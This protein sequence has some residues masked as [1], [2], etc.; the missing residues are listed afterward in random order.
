MESITDFIDL[1]IAV[2]TNTLGNDCLSSTVKRCPTGTELESSVSQAHGEAELKS[3]SPC[4]FPI[5]PPI[6]PST[7]N[8]LWGTTYRANDPCEDR[9]A[10][11]TN[12]LLRPN[13]KKR[14]HDSE[15]S[16]IT[17]LNE[18]S[19]MTS[20]PPRN[21]MH[22]QEHHTLYRVS[23]FCV[24]DGH[25]GPYVAD[26]ASKHLLPM[27]STNIRK[28][29]DCTY[30]AM[31][32]FRINHDF[33]SFKDD[34][35]D[36]EGLTINDPWYTSPRDEFCCPYHASVSKARAAEDTHTSDE[37]LLDCE[38]L[39][40]VSHVH[41]NEQPR[42][43]R[44]S[45]ITPT[46]VSEEDLSEGSH[47]PYSSSNPDYANIQDS[48][49]RNKSTEFP[50]L[51]DNQPI[52]VQT[53]RE[54]FLQLD[55]L[56]MNTINVQRLRPACIMTND[57]C[58]AGS[59]CLV[60]ML[61]QKSIYFI[62]SG[63]YVRFSS[64]APYLYTS[65]LGD[66]R[67]IILSHPSSSGGGGG[68]DENHNS[69]NDGDKELGLRDPYSDDDDSEDTEENEDSDL[70]SFS[71][72]DSSDSLPHDRVHLTRNRM[73]PFKKRRLPTNQTIIVATSTVPLVCLQSLALTRDHTPYNTT[74]EILVRQR[75]NN[76][77]NAIATAFSGG[78]KRV[79][80]S[81][82]V[83]RALGDAYLK[84]EQV[85]FSPYKDHVPYITA[86]PEISTKEIDDSAMFIVLGTDGVWEK[87]DG[88]KISKWVSKYFD[89]QSL[90]NTPEP[91]VD[92]DCH[93]ITNTSVGS[94]A[95]KRKRD[96]FSP[97]SYRS[98]A[99]RTKPLTKSNIS[100][101][102]AW[103]I[104]NKVRRTRKMKSLKSLMAFPPGRARRL[105]HDDITA[106]VIQ[107]SGFIDY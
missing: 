106:C 55:E 56:W 78:I 68:G 88:D 49:H 39:P 103:K 53:I 82:S 72:N 25:G 83:T 80:G 104:L 9:Y 59:C 47:I 95:L 87:V 2:D 66:C 58:N 48:S 107:L 63:K 85:S 62:D 57:K 77:P 67:A 91:L 4:C 84:C 12:I 105:R 98:I 30:I 52:I 38:T 8:H 33:M 17:S 35:N 100:D 11:L 3:S 43:L 27:L 96:S 97:L 34:D 21:P 29:L 54:T 10:S 64:E 26:F 94:S 86:C 14:T 28:A 71:S 13:S 42:E 61:I 32:E 81:L 99:T 75:C 92:L 19:S 74:E 23:M 90:E 70:S 36:D 44:K 46:M 102:I 73:I 15:I 60:T 24:M 7:A 65:H 101:V 69:D 93:S 20:H 50:S 1:N 51:L 18:L 22:Q 45:S 76:A 16:T 5:E 37:L 31:G 6:F 40:R 89:D 41:S 79:A